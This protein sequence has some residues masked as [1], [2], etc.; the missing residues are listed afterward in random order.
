MA[1]D[2]LPEVAPASCGGSS[3]RNSTTPRRLFTPAKAACASP[4]TP[5]T[6][7]ALP[8][9]FNP[10]T[11]VL[12]AAAQQQHAAKRAA[13]R[14]ATERAAAERAAVSSPPLAPSMPDAPAEPLAVQNFRQE[15][16][17]LMLQA[18]VLRQRKVKVER[19]KADAAPD[20]AL[21]AAVRQRHAHRQW[22]EM[23]RVACRL[24]EAECTPKT[25]A[26]FG[27]RRELDAM[28]KAKQEADS[29]LASAQ[30]RATAAEKAL[31]QKKVAEAEAK[32]A[33]AE[34]ALLQKKVAEAEAKAAAAEKKL[35][36]SEKQR[37]T[38]IAYMVDQQPLEKKAAEAEA[39]A[40]EAQ[41]K[42]AEAERT[43]KALERQR[44]TAMAHLVEQDCLKKRLVEAERML[45]TSEKQRDTAIAYM[46][47]QEP[48]EKKVAEA[49]CKVAEVERMLEMS[50]TQRDTAI[51]YMVDKGAIAY[52]ADVEMQEAEAQERRR[53]GRQQQAREQLAVARADDKLE[54]Q[55][56]EARERAAEAQE[57]IATPSTQ[58]VDCR[59]RR[60]AAAS[61]PLSGTGA[62]R[63]RR[64]RPA[65]VSMEPIALNRALALTYRQLKSL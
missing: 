37:D 64:P 24:W 43:S 16:A 30:E 6:E 13:K 53:E 3:G 5:L 38:A 8:F 18:E 33:A 42:A 26:Q 57:K 14:A 27:V 2:A 29:R 39:R 1:T 52:L 45:R 23:R 56:R 63:P 65:L 19:R 31:L 7:A 49:E 9:E 28:S 44:D 12:D 46:V 35:R 11:S 32:A 58:F 60:V 47:D 22:E 59:I 25:G 17:A 20:A 10:I 21:Q 34:K 48:L 50:E 61:S 54:R 4:G 40:A 41:A 62:V 51:A 36:T 15:V 55:L